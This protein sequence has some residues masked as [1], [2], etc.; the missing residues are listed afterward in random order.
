MDS[1]FKENLPSNDSLGVVPF[2]TLQDRLLSTRPF[3]LPGYVFRSRTLHS[4]SPGTPINYESVMTRTL[5][6]GVP[7][8]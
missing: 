5:E 6:Q 3:T 1:S 2:V 4:I 8:S 7:V